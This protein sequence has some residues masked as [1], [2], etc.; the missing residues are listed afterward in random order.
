MINIGLD[1][2]RIERFE[3]ILNKKPRLLQKIFSDYEWQYASLKN[4]SQTL[5]GI[6]C[7]KEAV[8][9]AISVIH[10]TQIQDISIAHTK[11]GVP[12]VSEIKGFYRLNDFDIKISISHSKG[13]AAAV[14]LISLKLSV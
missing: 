12:Y 4:T 11:N 10:Q 14:C 6:W 1:I 9:K 2:E 5:V 7:A 3:K 8:V 13:I